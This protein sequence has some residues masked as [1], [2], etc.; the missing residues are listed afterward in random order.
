LG[1][2]RSRP[3]AGS[4]QIEDEVTDQQVFEARE[5]VVGLDQADSHL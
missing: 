5:I 4:V 3:P 1:Y 2:V